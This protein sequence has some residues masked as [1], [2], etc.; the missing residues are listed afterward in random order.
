MSNAAK[1][2]EASISAERAIMYSALTGNASDTIRKRMQNR[3]P[4]RSAGQSDIFRSELFPDHP[5]RFREPDE[6]VRK[7]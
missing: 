6:M 1:C 2:P 5:D 3:R 4:E 7:K